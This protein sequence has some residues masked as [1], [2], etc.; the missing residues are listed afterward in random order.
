MWFVLSTS[1]GSRKKTGN[2]MNFPNKVIIIVIALFISGAANAGARLQVEIVPGRG[3]LTETS[4]A[5]KLLNVGDQTAF[6]D[7]S[8][9]PTVNGRGMLLDDPFIL[10]QEDGRE[11]E[12]I[13]IMRDTL[14]EVSR[15]LS[16][17]AGGTF[18][19]D[20]ELAKGYRLSPGLSYKVSLRAPVSYRSGE[21]RKSVV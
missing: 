17:P 2:E 3:G 19:V 7:K 11:A 4:I 9:V 10:K 1:V 5:L 8:S 15:L 18:R 16:I 20:I 12:F 6:V 14:P 13:G 21:D